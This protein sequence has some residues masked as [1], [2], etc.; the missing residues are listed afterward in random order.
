MLALF[1]AVAAADGP[2]P[3]VAALKANAVREYLRGAA[4]SAD[5]LA[6]VRDDGSFADVDYA[7]RDRGSWPAGASVERIRALAVAA[8]KNPE[9]P[10]FAD[11]FRRAL[12]HFL[13]LDPRNPNWWWNEIGVPMHLGPALVVGE[14]LLT[15]ELRDKG[16]RRLTR[17][18]FGMSGQNREL[19]AWCI[20]QR[21][22]L[23]GD[24]AHAR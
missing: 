13:D 23:E 17:V 4:A 20:L 10:R 3:A 9:A 16:V 2:P 7:S 8:A 21:A 5:S 24:E 18:R 14:G 15:P 11:A 22:I 12:G 1:A 6:S 19:I